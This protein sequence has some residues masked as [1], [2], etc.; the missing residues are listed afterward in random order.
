MRWTH[1]C[2]A[3]RQTLAH[4]PQIGQRKQR[5]QLRRVLG[6]SPVTNFH[7]SK[8]AFDDPKRVFHF[9]ADTGLDVFKLVELIAQ[10]GIYAGLAA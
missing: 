4:H 5:V 7:V 8:L 10:G 6:Q 9:G 1:S 3:P 2:Q